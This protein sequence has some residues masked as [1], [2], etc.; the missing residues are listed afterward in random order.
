VQGN[1]GNSR[2][3][4]CTN[5]ADLASEKTITESTS[6]VAYS[7]VVNSK[8]RVFSDNIT[9]SGIPYWR[10][11]L[12]LRENTRAVGLAQFLVGRGKS[13]TIY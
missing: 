4:E 11:V 13:N 6:F 5:K 2:N 1:T 8:L 12:V 9:N 10:G 7:H 3:N